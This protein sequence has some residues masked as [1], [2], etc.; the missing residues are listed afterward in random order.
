MSSKKKNEYFSDKRIYL[1]YKFKR[2]KMHKNTITECFIWRK[3]ILFWTSLA[4]QMKD[5]A[6]F[7]YFYF[8]NRVYCRVLQSTAATIL[9][10]S[11]KCFSLVMSKNF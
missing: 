1:G 2:K 10:Q 6:S 5:P 9:W 7:R 11:N 3:W 8:E 4:L